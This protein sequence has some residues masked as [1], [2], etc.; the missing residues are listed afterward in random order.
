MSGVETKP[1]SVSS[2]ALVNEWEHRTV[3]HILVDRFFDGNKGN[4]RV[5]DGDNLLSF[6][7]GDFIGVTKKLDLL[8]DLGIST[9]LINPVFDSNDYHGAFPLD[10]QTLNPR[11]GATEDLVHL[12]NEAHRRDITVLLTFITDHL[13]YQNTLPKNWFRNTRKAD[14]INDFYHWTTRTRM[15]APGTVEF[16]L[17]KAPVADYIFQSASDLIKLG[18]DGFV[19]KSA[20]NIEP[21]F[22]EKFNARIKSLAG[23]DFL[24]ISDALL[25]SADQLEPYIPHFDGQFNYRL[26]G[27]LNDVM[28]ERAAPEKLLFALEHVQSIH[29]PDMLSFNFLDYDASSRM[30][31]RLGNLERVARYKQ[32]LIFLFTAPGVPVILYGSEIGMQNHPKL[33]KI[34]YSAARAPMSFVNNEKHELFTFTQKLIALRRRFRFISSTRKDVAALSMGRVY[35]TFLQNPDGQKLFVV[36]NFDTSNTVASV[37]LKAWGGWETGRYRDILTDEKVSLVAGHVKVELGAY[38]SRVFVHEN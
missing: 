12:I 17:S 14:G 10:L 30:N 25:K 8:R 5:G 27:E 29:H 4:N 31:S 13:S 23:D 32:A 3:Y 24:V 6:Q 36:H 1:R 37:N 2:H 19:M 38:Q 7:G 35:L 11:Y 16:D 33:D 20:E 26:Y 15:S 34:H 22:W 28:V 21:W 18:V 9:L